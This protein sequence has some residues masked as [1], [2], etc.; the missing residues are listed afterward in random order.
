MDIKYLCPYWG[1]EPVK[2]VTFLN[3]VLQA[4]FDGVE[5]NLGTLQHKKEWLQ[6]FNNIKSAQPGFVVVA[7]MVLEDRYKTPSAFLSAMI[8]RLE[9]LVR[10]KPDFINSHTGKD[11]FSFK[12]NCLLIEASNTFSRQNNIEIYHETHRG[13]FSYAIHEIPKYL[14]KFPRLGLIADYSHWCN[15][16]ESMLQNQSALLKSVIPHIRHIH[17]RVGWEHGP[18]VADP[19]TKNAENY[20]QQFTRWWSDILRYHRKNGQQLFTIC[21]EAGPPPYMPTDGLGRPLAYQWSINVQMLQYLKNRF[22]K[23]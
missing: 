8:K 2:P 20:L 12:D 13:R 19:F 17:A 23:M 6:A 14:K 22:Q 10:F 9:I 18:Q 1:Q 4:G 15:V 11:F 5:V 3:K 21:T 7:Q 16:S